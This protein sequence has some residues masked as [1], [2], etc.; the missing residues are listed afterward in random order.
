MTREAFRA[1]VAQA[2]ET[3]PPPFA[4][5]ARNLAILVEDRPSD[6]VL[7]EMDIE[8]PDT[9]LG[10]Y[11]GT[12]LTERQWGHGNHAPDH[13][14]LFQQPIEAEADGDPDAL[15]TVIGETLIHE[16][17]HFFGMSED[18]LLDIEDRYWR[19]AGA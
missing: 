12:P 16:L 18:E 8:P 11:V 5:E 14:L 7:A 2:I 17:G 15:V 10:L 3:I 13:I 9:L 1:L 4:R 19:G 6:A